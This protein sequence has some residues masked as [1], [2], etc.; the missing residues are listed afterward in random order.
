MKKLK[1][2]LGKSFKVVIFILFTILWSLF[3]YLIDGEWLYFFPL[4][5]GD[6]LFWETIS[7]Q[8][9]KKKEKKKKKEKS[10]IKSWFNAILF[11]VVAATILRTFLI[12]AYTIPTSS[13]E[14]SLLIGDFLFVSKVSYGPRVPMTPIAFPLVHHTLPFTKKTPAYLKWIQLNYYRMKGLGD[15][16]RNDC[17]V[18]NYPADDA[19]HPERPIDKKENYIKR[20]VGIPGDVIEIKNTDL[21]VNG[22][23]QAISEK[24]RNQF[25]YFVKTDGTLFSERTLNKYNIYE[26]QILSRNGDYELMLNDESLAAIKRFTY[27][28]KV[29]KI[30]ID[31][32]I[33][34]NS[35]ELIF[36]E[37][38]FNWNLDNFGPI[39]IPQAGTQVEIDT[40]NIEL[41]RRIIETYENNK[42]EI[43][44][45][46]IYI[47]DN[48]A[49]N[50]TFKMDYYWMMGDNRHNSLDSRYWGF[51][52]EDHV[53]GKAL[54]IWMSWDKN[55][56]GINKIRWSRLFNAVH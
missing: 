20:C 10:E 49:S 53:V 4:I 56:K 50:Y 45:G 6:I 36:P 43:I 5:V 35:P 3:V 34:V 25:R 1:E 37:D 51:V 55:K 29:E 54:F 32:G 39:K 42:L 19:H 2:L 52:P 28:K 15:V 23:P 21:Y 24:M 26:G 47:N 8:F 46:E 16:E 13:M 40:K 22:E 38:N 33:K 41:Y 7:W 17:V 44:D 31:K 9:W 48:L 14:K 11:A 18:F 27:V 30:F 12:E